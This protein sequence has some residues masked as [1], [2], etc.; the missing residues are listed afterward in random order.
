[1]LTGNAS[2]RQV[3]QDSL[4]GRLTVLPTGHLTA[5]PGELLASPRL[6]AAMRSLTETFDVVLVDA[7]PLQGVA[8]PVVLSKVTDSALL[9][10]R[11]NRTPTADVERSLDLLE[12]V[13]ARLAGAV[14]NAL[15]RKLPTGTGWHQRP[16]AVPPPHGDLGLVTGRPPQ[17]Y[18]ASID[19]VVVIPP[20][21]DPVRG[22]ARVV[23]ST[24]IRS[25]TAQPPPPA[26]TSP[27]P[28]SPAAE[29][30]EP[31]R[32]RGQAKVGNESPD[33]PAQR[34]GEDHEKPRDDE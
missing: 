14:L 20:Q 7:P 30:S 8:D 27:A 2:V 16:R 21:P 23:K 9:V 6:G 13:G 3:L 29:R 26:P 24:L 15:P 31:E 12:R 5:D 1:M 28:V 32:P 4:D 19:T 25:S 22:R 34:A 11:A 10:V 33:L 17:D 18:P